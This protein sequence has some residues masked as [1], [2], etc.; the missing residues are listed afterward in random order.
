MKQELNWLKDI[1]V[2]GLSLY[3]NNYIPLSEARE[4]LQ[5]LDDKK[6]KLIAKELIEFLKEKGGTGALT[7]NPLPLEIERFNGM[8]ILFLEV[9][10]DTYFPFDHDEITSKKKG[11]KTIFSLG[12]EDKTWLPAPLDEYTFY[13]ILSIL[14]L[15]AAFDG[16][17]MEAMYG[18][19]TLIKLQSESKTSLKEFFEDEHEVA[20]KAL[21]EKTRND[22]KLAQNN[23]LKHNYTACRDLNIKG[24]VNEARKSGLITYKAKSDIAK[25][26]K[27]KSP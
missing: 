9:V 3:D 19:Y 14:I 12:Q 16:R 26:L 23:F 21:I 10:P 27:K 22:R 6:I 17:S 13:E 1:P 11:K 15:D 4:I 7:H 8:Q 18:V 25:Y 20:K 2:T 5:R 24:F